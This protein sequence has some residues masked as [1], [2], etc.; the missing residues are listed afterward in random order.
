MPVSNMP[1][2]QRVTMSVVQLSTRPCRMR[3]RPKPKVQ[4]DTGR[5]N[6][7]GLGHSGVWASQRTPNMRTKFLK[8]N[9]RRNFKQNIRDEEN[10]QCRIVLCPG[11]DV[12]IFSHA[13]DSGVADVY[14]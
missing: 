4:K 9:I 7:V 14:S 10:H 11:L 13:E 3:I 12:E 2:N 6:T 1:R 8:K 5:V